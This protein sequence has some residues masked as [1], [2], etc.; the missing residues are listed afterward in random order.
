M[1]I[2]QESICEVYLLRR[3]SLLKVEV[4][5]GTYMIY[6][7]KNLQKKY[8][9]NKVEVNALNGIDLELEAGYFYSFIGSSGSGKSTLLN[10]LGLLDT[11]TGGDIL[12]DGIDTQILN[13]DEKADLRYRKIGFI[14]QHYFLIPVLNVYE[15]IELPLLQNNQLSKEQLTKRINFLLEAVGLKEYRKHKP[16]ELSGG[17]RQRVA[18]ARALSMKPNVILADEPTANLDSKTSKDII[19]LMRELNQ[20]EKTTFIFSTHDSMIMDYSDKIF[21]I[22]DGK[23]L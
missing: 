18:I 10:L 9:L 1:S 13:E 7:I 8:Y 3:P 21:Q 14:F 5:G 17:Q 12:F 19:E 6:H 22:K 16:T 11:P 23:I 15:N 2:N 20:I 4:I